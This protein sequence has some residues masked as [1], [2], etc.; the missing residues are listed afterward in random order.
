LPTQVVCPVLYSRSEFFFFLIQENALEK[1][2]QPSPRLNL[3]GK[4]VLRLSEDSTTQIYNS[5]NKFSSGSKLYDPFG[6]V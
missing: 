4:N 6:T 5:T 1:T 2:F 3:D